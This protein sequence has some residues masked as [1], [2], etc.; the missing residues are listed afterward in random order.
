MRRVEKHIISKSNKQ[1]DELAWKTKN[2]YN[3]ANYFIR[4]IFI[5]TSKEKDQGLRTHAIML[6]YE[7]LNTIFSYT[8]PY[9]LLPPQTAQQTLRLLVKNW[10]SFFKSIKE[11]KKNP[12]KFLGRPCLPKYKD[13]EKGRSIVIFTNQ[14]ARVKN[15]FIHFHYMSGLKPLK[16][17]I[18]KQK[19]CQVRII[20]QATCYV[21]EVV[22][23]VKPIDLKLNSSH[24]LLIDLGLNNFATILDDQSL[25]SFIIKGGKVKSI[26]QLYNKQ[27]AFLKP[28]LEKD[29]YGSKK[30]ES[31]TYNRNMK[32]QDFL[33]KTSRYIINYCKDNDVGTIIIGKNDN[34]KQEINLGDKTNQSFVQIPF[35]RFI[36]MLE[37]KAE[38]ISIKVICTEESYTS[39]V[40]HLAYESMKHHDK[41]LGKRVKR[42]LFQSSTGL[43][44]NADLN[45]CIGIGRKV[46]GDS[47]VTKILNSG[48]ASNPIRIHGF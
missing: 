36:K 39:K 27:I 6:T 21:M 46:V 16:T 47:L 20:P 45:G 48:F 1:V 33:H 42:G 17:K 26:N 4:Q 41:Y 18:G 40:D 13:I 5:A 37:Y 38:E 12:D 34:W 19:L 28:Q 31:I 35:V 22:Y 25:K 24:R 32:V 7:Q 3:Y 23:E 8:T 14:Q 9:K 2:L 11:W 29:N 10:K 43:L 15:G 44:I 30:I